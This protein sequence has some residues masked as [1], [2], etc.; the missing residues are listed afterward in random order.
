MRAHRRTLAGLLFGGLLSL[1]LLIGISAAT[2]AR[3]TAQ[4][5]S[6]VRI[7]A[8]LSETPFAP[9]E[10]DSV[11]LQLHFSAKSSGLGYRILLRTRSYWQLKRSSSLRGSFKGNRIIP[12]AKLK[13]S[14]GVGHY[15]LE[16]N[17][18]GRSTTLYFD[19]V[20]ALKTPTVPVGAA[21][22]HSC[23]L[24]SGGRVKCWGGNH[25]G[26]LGNRT[27]TDS[28]TPVAASG[29]RNA[30]AVTTGGFTS[31][32]LLPGGKVKCWGDNSKGK[33]GAGPK[34]SSIST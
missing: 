22:T 32:A 4:A 6:S 12:F 10:T 34:Y 21:D 3:T 30:K 5:T 8:S 24:I 20:K 2:A 25:Y 33:L 29:I 14:I 26:Q 31:C 18:G 27:I 17:A 19:V 1:T 15:R 9:N 28:V 11:R 13:K 7:S 23:A 16:L